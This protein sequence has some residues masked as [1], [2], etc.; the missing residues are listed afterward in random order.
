MKQ[1]ENVD[2]GCN[3]E[4]ADKLG[5]DLPLGEGLPSMR[6]FPGASD[7][8]ICPGVDSASKN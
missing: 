5:V 4:Y 3:Y 2:C 8:S 6:I 1:P 7:S